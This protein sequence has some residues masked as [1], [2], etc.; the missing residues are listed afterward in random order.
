MNKIME[1]MFFGLRVCR[2]R[3][4]RTRVSA[5][6][7]A[8]YAEPKS[9]LAIAEIDALLDDGRRRQQM[10]SQGR[11][12]VRTTLACAPHDIRTARGHRTAGE[13][14]RAQP[15]TA[16]LADE[17]GGPATDVKAHDTTRNAGTSHNN[18]VASLTGWPSTAKSPHSATSPSTGPKQSAGRIA[19]TPQF[20]QR[21][22]LVSQIEQVSPPGGT[23]PTVASQRIG[24]FCGLL[25]D[26][27][28]DV[29]KPLGAV[30]LRAAQCEQG[31]APLF[32]INCKC[33]YKI[34]VLVQLVGEHNGILDRELRT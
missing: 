33:A 7:A 24:E 34:V 16:W 4:R 9:E 22:P 2:L 11:E 21:G 25:V 31:G 8:V 20:P 12:R 23:R 29:L 30:A 10:G 13:D 28:L 6:D 17:R 1:Y 3:P 27:A 18:D 5:G 19:A 26:V 14:A 32:V 15:S